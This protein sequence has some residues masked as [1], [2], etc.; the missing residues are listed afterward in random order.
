M[1]K[2]SNPQKCIPI[3]RCFDPKPEKSELPIHAL[4]LVDTT[5]L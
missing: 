5:N 3:F 1:M 4:S 2:F